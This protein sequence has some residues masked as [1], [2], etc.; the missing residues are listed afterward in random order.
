MR[1]AQPGI[2]CV[3]SSVKEVKEIAILVFLFDSTI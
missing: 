1:F 3:S 2:S